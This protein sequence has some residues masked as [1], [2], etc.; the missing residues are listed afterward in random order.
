MDGHL[1]KKGFEKGCAGFKARS[2]AN[3]EADLS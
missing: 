3:G 2:Q 1:W